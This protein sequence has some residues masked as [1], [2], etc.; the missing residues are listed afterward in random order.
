MSYELCPKF[1]KIFSILG[2][3]WNGLILEVLL[4]DGDQR[5]ASLSRKIP[6]ISDRVLVERLKELEREHLVARYEIRTPGAKVH[7][8]YGLTDRGRALKQVMA[9]IHEWAEVWVRDEECNQE[10]L[11]RVN[12]A[13]DK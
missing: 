3:K 10:L 12:I 13:S 11:K 2:R 5:F 7:V 6:G 1:E 9:D 8:E 4:S